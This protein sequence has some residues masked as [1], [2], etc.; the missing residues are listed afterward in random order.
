MAFFAGEGGDAAG[1]GGGQPQGLFHLGRADSPRAMPAAVVAPM[2]LP[3]ST[4]VA[5]GPAVVAVSALRAAA[6]AW[7]RLVSS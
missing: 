6:T 3:A 2:V 5:A 7:V 1:Q 4:R